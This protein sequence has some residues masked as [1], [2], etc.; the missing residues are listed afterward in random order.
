MA[1]CSG[2]IPLPQPCKR[3]ANPCHYYYYYYYH[4]V[5]PREP[6]RTSPSA[7]RNLHLAYKRT[8]PP[9]AVKQF[10]CH[11]RSPYVQRQMAI[12]LSDLA[13]SGASSGEA[14]IWGKDSGEVPNG[15][16]V[17]TV[18]SAMPNRT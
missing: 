10:K 4:Y 17:R 13:E 5:S 6:P 8:S 18:A 1:T 15:L 7:S 3:R 11:P 2:R 12:N 16:S 14:G 9:V